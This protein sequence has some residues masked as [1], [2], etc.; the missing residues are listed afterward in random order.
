[1]QEQFWLITF[2]NGETQEEYGK[3]E[4]DVRDFISRCF[5]FK[6]PIKSVELHPSSN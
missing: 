5:K 3:D 2:E 6:G 4:A 1:M